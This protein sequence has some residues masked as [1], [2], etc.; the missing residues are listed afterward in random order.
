MSASPSPI[1]FSRLPLPWFTMR[2]G[3]TY[4]WTRGNDVSANSG[5]LVLLLRFA[6]L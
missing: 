6:V 1:S 5:G 2:A 4:W 3:Y